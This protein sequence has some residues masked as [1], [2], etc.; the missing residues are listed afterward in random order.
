MLR[1]MENNEMLDLG[2]A[3][4]ARETA[5]GSEIQPF[6][7]FFPFF[8]PMPFLRYLLFEQ[9][10][11]FSKQCRSYCDFRSTSVRRRCPKKDNIFS[12]AESK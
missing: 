11:F 3:K 1:Q 8:F 7:I 10:Y 12:S 2:M 5:E 4:L 6:S 9:P